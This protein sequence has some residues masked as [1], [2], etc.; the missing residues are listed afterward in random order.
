MI[1]LGKAL[2][3]AL[4]GAG[5]TLIAVGVASGSLMV[6]AGGIVAIACG[7]GAL[8]LRVSDEKGSPPQKPAP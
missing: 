4:I 5:S 6:A 8:A 3:A 1:D 7:A 2:D